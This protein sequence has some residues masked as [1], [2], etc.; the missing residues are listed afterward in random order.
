MEL[1]L[2][3]NKIGSYLKRKFHV[4]FYTKPIVSKYVGF[5]TRDIIYECRCGER[6][7]TEVCAEYGESFPIE[8]THFLSFA[9]F[10]K[11]L[12]GA[13]PKEVRGY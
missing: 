13:N 2:I 5:Y 3:L 11:I 4:H 7:V 6:K 12:E 1:V 8:T 9:D 10:D